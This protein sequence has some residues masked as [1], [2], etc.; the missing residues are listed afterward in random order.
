M[1]MN[2]KNFLDRRMDLDK[3]NYLRKLIK[4]EVSDFNH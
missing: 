3:D 1:R 4:R 2:Q